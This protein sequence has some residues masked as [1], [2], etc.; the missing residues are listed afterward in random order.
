MTLRKK[1]I[2]K[3]KKITSIVQIGLLI[4]NKVLNIGK[5]FTHLLLKGDGYIVS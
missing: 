4:D 2:S 5:D 1:G 3:D